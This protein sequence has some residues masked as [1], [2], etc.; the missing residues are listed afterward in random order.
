MIYDVAGEIDPATG[1][2]AYGEVI[3]IGPRQGTGKT[4]LV[5]PAMTHRCNGFGQTLHDWVLRELGIRLAPALPQSVMYIAQS[6][7]DSRT[8][9]RDVHVKRL[10]ESPFGRPVPEFEARLTR[11]HEALMWRN[12]STWVPGS[13]VAGAAGTGDSLDMGV[14]DE[15][16]SR[17]DFRTEL[18]LKPAMLT[19][20]WSQ[21]WVMSMIPGPSRVLPGKWRYLKAKRDL[22]RAQVAAGRN[23]DVAFFDFCGDPDADP[24]DP[25]TWYSAIPGLGRTVPA[26]KI[27]AD[28]AGYVEGGDL[29][30]FKAEYLGIEPDKATARWT[31]IAEPTWTALGDPDSLIVGSK[32]LAVEISQDRTRAWIAVAGYRADGQYHV[33]VIEPGYRVLPHIEGVDWVE[34]RV[35]EIVRADATI[36]CVVIDPKRP[37]VSLVVPLT[38]AGVKVLTPNLPDIAGACGRF[39]DATGQQREDGHEVA[40]DGRRVRHLG[41]QAALN[42]AVQ[43]AT[44]FDV[45]NGQFVFVRKGAGIEIGPLYAVTLAMHGLVVHGTEGP[46]VPVEDT[47]DQSRPCTRCGRYVFPDTGGAW[48]HLDDTPACDM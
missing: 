31:M 16:W 26:D 11:K 48:V 6:T 9:W 44:P 47:V 15:A 45:G 19:R 37:A 8:K 40:D 21:L 7:E 12:G 2:L 14:I 34:R 35:L 30:D 5:L 22:G 38:K 41:D 36:A 17:L 1:S 3:V 25:D 33:E 43:H 13:T 29:A 20:W 28:Y 46:P 39:Y 4:E 24:G 23:R 27:R 18:G 32:A 42:R 10:Q